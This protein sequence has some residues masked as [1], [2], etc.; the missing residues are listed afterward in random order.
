[1]KKQ[2]LILFSFLLIAVMDASA[3]IIIMSGGSPTLKF[4]TIISTPDKLI[5]RG[6]GFIPCPVDFAVKNNEKTV[7]VQG[8]VNEIFERWNSGEKSGEMVYEDVIPVT[9]ETDK[10]DEITI[11]TKEDEVIFK[12]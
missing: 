10:D 8:I 4:K 1:M 5:C 2:L 12:K 7:P 9:W 11:T 3:Y 6:T